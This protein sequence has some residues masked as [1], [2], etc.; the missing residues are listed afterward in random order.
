LIIKGQAGAEEKTIQPDDVK[1]ETSTERGG[2]FLENK[3]QLSPGHSLTRQEKGRPTEE[4]EGES[5]NYKPQGWGRKS[6]EMNK[7][8]ELS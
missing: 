5:L 1:K 2:S 4:K 6:T 7:K 8:V 3:K